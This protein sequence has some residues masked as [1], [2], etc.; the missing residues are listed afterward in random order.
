M[1]HEKICAGQ[2][3]F[4]LQSLMEELSDDAALYDLL[5]DPEACCHCIHDLA[6]IQLRMP[7]PPFAVALAGGSTRTEVVR[8]RR[9][10]GSFLAVPIEKRVNPK[11]TVTVC[12]PPELVDDRWSHTP[13]LEV[14]FQ[15]SKNMPDTLLHS[16]RE[17]F[18]HWIEA[19]A[20]IKAN[21]LPKL[22]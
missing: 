22:R 19:L 7:W 18:V 4:Q 13:H 9:H 1:T 20:P 3:Q 21:G 8:S 12:E 16:L 15:F 2:L 6:T 10:D 14:T 17:T 5:V 11:I